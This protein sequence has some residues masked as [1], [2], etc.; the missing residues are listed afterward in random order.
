[1][2]INRFSS[3]VKFILKYVQFT[4]F[5]LIFMNL[6]LVIDEFIIKQRLQHKLAA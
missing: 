2:L 3:T 1:M 6:Y 4:P 5:S